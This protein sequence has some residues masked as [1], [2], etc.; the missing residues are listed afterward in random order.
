[1]VLGGSD[2]DSKRGIDGWT[3]RKWYLSGELSVET[4]TILDLIFSYTQV[5]DKKLGDPV[6]ETV[7]M[8]VQKYKPFIN[9]DIAKCKKIIRNMI[10]D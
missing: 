2:N 9:I 5:F 8:K 3:L 7:S 10:N 4:I 6:W 1:M